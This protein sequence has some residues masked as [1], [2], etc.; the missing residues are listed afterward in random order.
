MEFTSRSASSHSLRK[1]YA[2]EEI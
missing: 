2:I 1:D